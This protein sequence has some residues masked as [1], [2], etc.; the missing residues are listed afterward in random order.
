MRYDL[1]TSGGS[2]SGYQPRRPVVTAEGITKTYGLVRA[3]RDVRISLYPGEVLGLIGPNGSG[4]ST[5]I[6]VLSGVTQ[7]DRGKVTWFGRSG[8]MPGEEVGVIHQTLGLIEGGTVLENMALGVPALRNGLG[9]VDGRS[10]RKRARQA[11]ERLGLHI[12]LD[13]PVRA[14]APSSRALVAVARLLQTEKRVVILDEVT[15][16]LSRREA[17]QMLS[18][19]REHMPSDVAMIFVSHKFGELRELASR[20][21]VLRDGT[22]TN[23]F[24]GDLPSVQELTRLFAPGAATEARVGDIGG[25]ELGSSRHTDEGRRSDGATVLL[26]VKEVTGEG[27]GPFTLEVRAGEVVG[28]V[29]RMG[30]GIHEMAY[31]IQGLWPTTSGR[32]LLHPGAIRAGVPAF[33]E[34]E[35]VFGELPV[36]MNFTVGLLNRYRRW[37]ALLNLRAERGEAASMA[38][39]LKVVPPDYTLPIRALSGGNQ[40]KV[41]FGRAMLANPR[42]FVLCEPT[43]GVDV[44]TR[45]TI[46]ALIREFKHGGSGIVIASSDPDDVASVCD[47]VLWVEDGRITQELKQGFTAE[48]IEQLL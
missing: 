27:V 24:E 46:Y 47:R 6:R 2:P 35:G 22:V 18:R 7:P 11:L 28:L 34:T 33:R 3:L 41:L 13:T 39:H 29:G 20:I 12:G 4:K 10:E 19:L 38:D 43:R 16:T 23:E 25:R 17:D 14:L 5:L 44:A 15:A 30:S 32:L 26:E 31:L 48:E 1:T 21:V 37:R 8:P 40:Q 45:R 36:Y 9:F 42:I